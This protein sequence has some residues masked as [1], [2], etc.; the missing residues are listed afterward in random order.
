[1]DSRDDDCFLFVIK[2]LVDSTTVSL[3]AQ[4]IYYHITEGGE[5]VK[6]CLA[7]VLL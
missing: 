3:R 7:G 5:N 1:M 4:E 2:N 6:Q